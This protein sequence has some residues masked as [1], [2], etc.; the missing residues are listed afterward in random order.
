MQF[1]LNTTTN[2]DEPPRARHQ[3]AHELSDETSIKKFFLIH[4]INMT[5][6]LMIITKYPDMLYTKFNKA[7]MSE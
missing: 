3:I 2:Q 4:R 1:L 5:M 6:F 7:V